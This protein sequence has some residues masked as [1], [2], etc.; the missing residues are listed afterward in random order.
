MLA[1]VFHFLETL[2][3]FFRNTN[4]VI[5]FSH[6]FKEILWTL[7]QD[8][9]DT[10][11]ISIK[12]NQFFHQHHVTLL[13]DGRIMMLD[14]HT[15]PESKSRR[16]T[17]VVIYELDPIIGTA[18][19]SWEYTATHFLKIGNRGSV[20]M[21]ENGNILAFY[22]RSL[23]EKDHLIEID[24]KTR[25]PK[26]HFA[27]YFA[28]IKKK[29]TQNQINWLKKNKKQV[30]LNPITRGGGNRASA[31]HSIGKEEFIGYEY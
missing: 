7:G 19:I 13:D 3:F 2:Y 29:I 8:P 10:Y 18:H 5:M 9:S 23:L 12:K 14:N 24:Y 21:L 11:Y 17:R 22:P 25:R 20:E 15:G 28:T 26:G 30:N 27:V 6:D 4:K 31:I 16:G 1:T